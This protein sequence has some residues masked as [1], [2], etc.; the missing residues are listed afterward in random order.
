MVRRFG[1]PV[2]DL[3]PGWYL[4][5][6]WPVEETVRVSQQIRTV[7]I[8]FRESLQTNKQTG[9]MTWS[10]AHRKETRIGEEALMITGD[11]NL[12]D[13]LVS[14]R[15]RVTEPRV[16]LFQVNNVDEILRAA[17]E[18]ELRSMVAGR[19]FL[20]L[21]TS[22][23]G[24][25]QDRALERIKAR[26]KQLAYDGLGIEIDSIAIVDLHPPAEV[27]DDYYR[28]AEAMENRDRDINLAEATKTE[29][30]QGRRG[31]GPANRLPGTRRQGRK[32]RAS[33]GGLPAIQGPAPGTQGAEFRHGARPLDARGR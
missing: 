1:E 3:E 5:Y 8:G 7:S 17:T 29:K 12:V 22:Q 19:P 32:V 27:V 30:T 15:F 14:V 28:V 26:C 11:G 20:D 2:A 10:S 6:P 33:P 31:R 9:A 21:L 24:K 23:R 16:Y 13:V 4:R 25:F 18:S